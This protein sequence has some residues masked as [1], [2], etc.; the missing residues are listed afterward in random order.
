[1]GGVGCRY[2]TE[3][4]RRSIPCIEKWTKLCLAVCSA[5]YLYRSPPH[6]HSVVYASL[7][8]FVS[9]NSTTPLSSTF[10]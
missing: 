2:E 10:P 8:T 7:S 6:L 5:S 3:H 4:S 1:M 9:T